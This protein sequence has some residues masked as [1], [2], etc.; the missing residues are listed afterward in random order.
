MW[1]RKFPRKLLIKIMKMLAKTRSLPTQINLYNYHLIKWVNRSCPKQNNDPR[2]RKLNFVQ[3]YAVLPIPSKFINNF[4]V[5]WLLFCLIKWGVWTCYVLNPSLYR[6]NA[7]LLQISFN[8]LLAYVM[9]QYYLTGLKLHPYPLKFSIH[10]L[11]DAFLSWKL[12]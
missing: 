1:R 11:L 7:Q 4:L 5:I 6:S 9:F 10:A 2:W 8:F 3:Y 12:L